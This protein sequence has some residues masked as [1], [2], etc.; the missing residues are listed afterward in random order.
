VEPEFVE[1]VVSGLPAE[2]D[3]SALSRWMRAGPHEELEFE[4]GRGPAN[5]WE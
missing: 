2:V 5:E 3:L 4:A 1:T